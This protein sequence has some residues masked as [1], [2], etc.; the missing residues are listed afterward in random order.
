MPQYR[1]TV[2]LRDAA[3]KSKVTR[4]RLHFAHKRSD[5]PPA[6]PLLFVHG[7]PDSF[8]EALKIIEPLCNPLFLPSDVNRSV[9]AFNVVVPSVP[10]FGFGDPSPSDDFGLEETADAFDAL[11]TRLGYSKYIVHGTGW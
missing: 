11:M 6:V 10:G 3:D 4:L 9:T 5:L 1:T 8:L 7:W 2:K